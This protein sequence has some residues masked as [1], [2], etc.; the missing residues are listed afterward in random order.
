MKFQ[1][2]KIL[3]LANA[4]ESRIK[5][6]IRKLLSSNTKTIE[7]KLKKGKKTMIENA[8]R[9]RRKQKCKSRKSSSQ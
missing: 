5:V 2:R 9:V 7:F 6:L 1:A 3:N 4:L 8:K